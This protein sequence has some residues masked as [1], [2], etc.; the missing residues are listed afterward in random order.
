MVDR[1]CLAFQ[2]I[3]S[4]LGSL[5]DFLLNVSGPSR[6]TDS[7]S[8]LTSNAEAPTKYATAGTGESNFEVASMSRQTTFQR[9]PSR[10][11]C[12][13]IPVAQNRDFFGRSEVLE[14]I[15]EIFFSKEHNNLQGNAETRTFAICG[16]G[17]MGKT[18][19]A[20]EFVYSRQDK[21]DAIFWIHADSAL[22]LQEEVKIGRAHV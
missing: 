11:P 1:E 10:F 3:T 22:K 15:D 16:P 4:P 18:Q 13:I 14:Q 6:T 5:T 21:F 8:N 9:Q 19:A 7:R 2:I 17:G 20:A 12:Y